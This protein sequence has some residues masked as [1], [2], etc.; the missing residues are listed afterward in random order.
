MT[1]TNEPATSHRDGSPVVRS[2]LTE[3]PYPEDTPP[4]QD[5]TWYRF[6]ND[7]A[8][9]RRAELRIAVCFMVTAAAS[10]A[11]AV[12]Y[13]LGGQPQAEGALLFFAFT[14]LGVGFV[15]W[16][17]DLLPGHDIAE[18]RG[19]HSG[20]ETARQM[21]V[22]ALN[23]GLDPMMERRLLLKVLGLAGGVFGIVIAFPIASFGERPLRTLYHT[24]WRP[25]LRLVADD[26]TPVRLGDLPINGIMTV[27]P[28]GVTDDNGLAASQTLLLN[29]GDLPFKVYPGHGDWSPILNGQRYVAF[30][31]VCTHAGCPVG[32]YNR[33]SHQLVCPCHQST[34]DV[35]GRCNP[36][37]GPA[38]RSLPQLPMAVNGDG[39][40]VARSD[41]TEAIGPGFWNRGDGSNGVKPT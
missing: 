27:F 5:D 40:L 39:Y 8:G 10:V 18:D 6:R 38:S 29:I 16:A 17:R 20:S 37:F 15:L 41:Y 33:G 4:G 19:D 31:K 3:G 25:G 11:L 34:F 24:A 30:S 32:L 28:E 7:P 21:V 13:V 35:L 2:D 36:V 9:A 22:G 26:G 12:V 1:T 23:R 14:G